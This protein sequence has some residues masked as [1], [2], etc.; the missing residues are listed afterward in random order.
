MLT[1]HIA[2][3]GNISEPF[4]R[5][6]DIGVRMNARQ[7][8][9]ELPRFIINEVVE[10][11]GAERAALFIMQGDQGKKQKV[12]AGAHLP[13][14]ELEADFVKRI[15]PIINEVVRLSQPV[16]R[17]SPAKASALKQRSILCIPLIT[18]DKLVGII[19][20]ELDGS[21]GRFYAQDLDLLKVLANQSAVA[22]SNA[23]WAHTLEKKVEQRTA[24][25]QT[26]KLTAEQRA[27][28]LAIINSDPG[29]A[30]GKIRYPGHL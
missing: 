13:S 15:Q 1:D 3:S 26:A 20:A 23:E 12:L 22:I 14:D 4:K 2:H 11:T 9:E 18:S 21:F 19:Y 28:E 5:L 25:L 24:E 30:C 8:P 10:L 16:L 27:A 17:Y 7:N 6:I 29:V